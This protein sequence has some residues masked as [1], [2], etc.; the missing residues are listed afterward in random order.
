[1]L[2][3]IS[4]DVEVIAATQHLQWPDETV[5]LDPLSDQPEYKNKT[6]GKWYAG[7][8]TS[9]PSIVINQATLKQ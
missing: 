1:M 9:R 4:K 7:L 3:G 5:D 8:K 2:A 6:S